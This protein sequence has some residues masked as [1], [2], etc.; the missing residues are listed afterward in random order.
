MQD[1]HEKGGN[2]ED[3]VRDYLRSDFVRLVP[4]PKEYSDDE[5]VDAI[6]A[7]LFS[8]AGWRRKG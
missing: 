8:K 1:I 4:V 3:I 6:I 5:H 2:L 7:D